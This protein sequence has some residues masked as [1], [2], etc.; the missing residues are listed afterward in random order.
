MGQAVR[1][2]VLL[3]GTIVALA[4]RSDERV[5]RILSLT[6]DKLI[7]RATGG[8]VFE[9]VDGKEFKRVAEVDEPLQPSQEHR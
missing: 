3:N 9:F 5:E 7:F 1:L 6:D 2:S 8:R 4:G